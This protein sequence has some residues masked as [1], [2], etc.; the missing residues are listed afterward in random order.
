MNKIDALLRRVK[1]STGEWKPH[2][3][4]ITKWD[5]LYRVHRTLWNGVKESLSP[6]HL[7]RRGIN[8]YQTKL[9]ESKEEAQAQIIADISKFEKEHCMKISPAPLV[10][11]CC[12]PE[13]EA[14]KKAVWREQGGIVL[15]YL[16]ERAGLT[17]EEYIRREYGPPV[18]TEERLKESMERYADIIRWR[19]EGG[20]DG[21]KAAETV[22][23]A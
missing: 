14:E 5:G 20:M 7:K 18:G 4:S 16:A 2:E 23:T 10:H 9:C 22:N 6:D 19:K 1:Q 8:P 21:E 12:L 17:L 3:Y 11:D 13:T 15:E